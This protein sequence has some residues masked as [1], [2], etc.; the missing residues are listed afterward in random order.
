VA[1]LSDESGEYEVWKMAADGSGTPAQLTKNSKTIISAFAVSPNEQYI[2][3]NDKNDV[4]RV[5]DVKT[6]AVKFLYD[7]AYA[8]NYEFSWS[9]NGRFLTYTAGIENQNA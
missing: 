9:P 2:A 8:G 3:Y 5:A 7:S 1:V 4:L 6:G